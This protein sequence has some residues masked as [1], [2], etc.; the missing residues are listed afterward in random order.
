MVPSLRERLGLR[1]PD[2]PISAAAAARP[3][4]GLMARSLMYLFAI[5]GL[6]TLVSLAVDGAEADTARLATTAGCA[7]G[8]AAFVLVAYDRTPEWGFDVLLAAGT[9]LI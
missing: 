5:G 3:D 8:I 7:I 6:L 4:R 1:V 2:Q 9:V